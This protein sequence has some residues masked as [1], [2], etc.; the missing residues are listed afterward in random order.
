MLVTV[1]PIFLLFSFFGC[2]DKKS[3]VEPETTTGIPTVTVTFPEGLTVPECAKLLEENGVCA[4]GDFLAAVNSPAGDFPYLQLIENPQ[5]R[6][7]LLEGYIFPDTYE[8]YYNMDANS[9]LKKF[10]DNFEQKIT[11]EHW[12]RAQELGYT[13]DEVLRIA[14]VIQEEALNPEMANVSSVLH[15]RLNSSYGKLEC[16][17][18][19][20]YLKNSVAPYVENIDAYSELYNTYKFSG[21]PAGPIANVGLKAVEAAL[22]PADTDYYFFVTDEDMNFY[23]AET[24][25]EHSANVE[26]YY[27]AK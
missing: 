18:T 1:L 5:Q 14:S 7:F 15:N 16:D 3:D 12:L 8:F 9:V 17:V 24:W 26:K 10:L 4:A 20:F 6:P 25:A 23:Y 19:V 11:K 22:Y 13:I 21:L 2:A 27:K